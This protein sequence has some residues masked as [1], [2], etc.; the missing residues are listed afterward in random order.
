MEY[1]NTPEVKLPNGAKIRSREDGEIYTVHDS[2]ETNNQFG[3]GIYRYRVE[4]RLD[5]GF[6]LHWK[7]F[8]VVGENG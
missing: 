5:T 6:A 8:D 2:T 4:E 7:W 3:Y 1:N